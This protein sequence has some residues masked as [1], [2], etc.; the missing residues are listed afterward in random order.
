MI[1]TVIFDMDGT[2]ID[3]EK[4]YRKCWPKAMAHFG[5]HMTDEQALSIRSLGQPFAPAY[6]REMFGDEEMDYEAIRNYR[7]QL[8][9]ECIRQN[10]IDLKPGVRELLAFLKEHHIQSAIATATDMERTER[11]LKQ[12]GLY[13]EFD[14][15]VS[16]SMVKEGKPAPDIYL[17]ACEACG[18]LPEECMAVEDSPNGVLSAY[19][20]GCRVVMV[21]DQTQPDEELQKLLYAKADSLLEIQNFLI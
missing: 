3:T 9:E 20:A 5:Y 16:A 14:R 21:P 1:K 7:K 4:Y 18:C 8:M 13:G 12:I 15:I 10:G 17:Y 11:Y 19:R 2:L 6:L